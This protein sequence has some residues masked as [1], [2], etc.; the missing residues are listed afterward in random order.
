M[1]EPPM[2]DPPQL[3]AGEWA[4]LARDAIAAG[5]F[6]LAARIYEAMGLTL[7][8][9]KTRALGARAVSLDTMPPD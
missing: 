2:Q 6:Y 9:G 4:L 1:A 8:A 3:G 7:L 5:H